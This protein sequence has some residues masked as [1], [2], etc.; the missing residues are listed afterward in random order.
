MNEKC[1]LIKND[2]ILREIY[3]LVVLIRNNKFWSGYKRA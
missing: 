3:K 1:N 2:K